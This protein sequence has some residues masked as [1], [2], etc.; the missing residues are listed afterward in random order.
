MLKL[1]GKLLGLLFLAL[2]KLSRIFFLPY[3]A[4]PQIQFLQTEI[5]RLKAANSVMKQYIHRNHLKPSFIARCRMVLFAFRFQIPFRRIHQYLPITKSTIQRYISKTRNNLL[6]LRT[7]SSRPLSSPHRTAPD[8]VSLIWNIKA[9]NPNWGYLRI[10]IHLWHLKIFISPSTVR[11]FLQKP[12]PKPGRFKGNVKV[13]KPLLIITAQEPNYLWSL[14]LTTLY[15]F[16]IFPVYILGIIDH[17]SRKVFCLSS[18]FHPNAEWVGSELK[19]LFL[20]FGFPKRII[21][22]NGS[23]F[24]SGSFKQLTESNKITH[25]KTSIRHPQS[26]GKI[27]RF[28]QSLKY[29]FLNFL[30]LTSKRHLDSLLS[31]Y[32]HYYNQF[33]LHEALDGQSPDAVYYNK[34]VP[35]P[36]KSSKQIRAPIETISLGN[37][38]LKA[39]QLKEAA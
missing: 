24:V 34:T 6:D 2:C 22:D 21:T 13:K 11:R 16:G 29:E 31:E 10:S 38:L 18:T 5:K 8:I 27:E 17:Y 12:R 37:G 14:D 15:I 4:D 19:N 35:K 26:N 23:P 20:L 3:S 39:Y 33:R 25:I 30:F 32:I 7:K 9:D 36:D 1:I 28:F